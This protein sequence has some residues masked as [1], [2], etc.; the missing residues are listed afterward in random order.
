MGVARYARE[1]GWILDWR[2]AAHLGRERAYLAS[3]RMD[4]V[5]SMMPRDQPAMRRLIRAVRV[6]VVDLG[7]D[8]P[9][10]RCPRVLL[11]QH[12]IGR[13]GAGHLLDRGIRQLLFYSHTVDV[14]VAS[15][16]WQ[17]F[18]A[19]AEERGGTARE[20]VWDSTRSLPRGRTRLDWL[21]AALL[22][23]PRPI[24]VMTVNDAVA[25]D[26]LQAADRAGLHVPEKVAV[27]GV[28]NDPIL[29]T[30]G[31][32]PLSSI[33]TAREVAGYEA[34]ALLDRLM[35]GD[36]APAA[37]LLIPPVG[38]VT[39]QSTE[40]SAVADANLRKVTQF[41]AEHFREPISVADVADQAFIGR[42]RLQ[43]LF[44]DTFGRSVHEE[45]LRQRLLCSQRLLSTTTH[46]LDQVAELSGFGT[47]M[48]LSKTFR[49]ELNVTPMEY[50]RKHRADG[51]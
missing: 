40:M 6:P 33:D 12:A 15:V 38:V 27:V 29:T 26:V 28:D 16:R 7:R 41:I 42:R 3:T 19:Q 18:R 37:T 48:Q 10:I 2:L 21:A 45:I 22:K 35:D 4:G 23:L 39:R 5:I 44:R 43:D 47:G 9:E 36:P 49:R 46:K 34:A 14:R 32:V 11:D 50:R 8:F 13:M 51:A 17:G 31:D 25:A 30:L 20:L 1:H 24:G